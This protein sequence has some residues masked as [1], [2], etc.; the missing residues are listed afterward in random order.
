[1][2]EQPRL[3]CRSQAAEVGLRQNTDTKHKIAFLQFAS[4]LRLLHKRDGKI[5]SRPLASLIS[6]STSSNEQMVKCPK[7]L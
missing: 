2:S 6:E 4:F 7:Y 1:M 5:S 3:F